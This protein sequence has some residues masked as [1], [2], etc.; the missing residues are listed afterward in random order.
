MTAKNYYYCK[1]LGLRLPKV[2]YSLY[3][4]VRTVKLQEC[5]DFTLESSKR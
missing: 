1:N 4:F 5:T 3:I 2:L